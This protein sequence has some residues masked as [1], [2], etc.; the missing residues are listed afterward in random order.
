MGL[1]AEQIGTIY[2]SHAKSLRRFLRSRVGCPATADDLAQDAF[3][4]LCT[5]A[6]SAEIDDPRSYLFRIAH[7]LVVDHHRWVHRKTGPGEDAIDLSSIDIEGMDIPSPESTA[8]E[9]LTFREEVRDVERSLG[10]L[11]ATCRQIFWLSRGFG[12]RNYEIA[13]MLGV[14]VST[15]EKNLSKAVRCFPGL[16]QAG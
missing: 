1:P 6:S 16:S 7:N 3:V 10:H 13:S 14:C 12:F 11:S 9:M 8:E 15:V 5:T 4:R 2:S